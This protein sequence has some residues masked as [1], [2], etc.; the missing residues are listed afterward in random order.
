V[1]QAQDILQRNKDLCARKNVWL[2]LWQ[3]LAD[4]YYPN[5]GGFTFPILAGQETQVEIYDTTPML[6]RRGL[7]TASTVCSSL[8]RPLVLDEG[9]DDAVNEDDQAK[10]WFDAVGDKMWSSI[11]DPLARFIQHS[12]AVDNDLATF[13]LGYLWIGE[14]RNRDG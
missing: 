5:R 13:G 9:K 7:A 6:A 8:P 14:N 4:M 1:T 10:A 2:P 12:G 3:S 11:Y